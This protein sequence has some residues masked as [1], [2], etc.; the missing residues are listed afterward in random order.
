MFTQLLHKCGCIAKRQALS[1]KLNLEVFEAEMKHKSDHQKI[2]HDKWKC[3]KQ[4]RYL[5]KVVFHL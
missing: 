5:S 3:G 2:P 4:A 1:L